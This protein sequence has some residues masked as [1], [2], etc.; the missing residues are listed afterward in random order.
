MKI[1]SR[2]SQRHKASVRIAFAGTLLCAS[3]T[4]SAK[5]EDEYQLKAA[6]LVNFLKFI[7]WP[8]SSG[9]YIIE[10]AGKN[11]FGS[12]LE[13]LANN[14]N[15]NGRKV[16]FRSE[17]H[18]G[19]GLPSIIFVPASELSRFADFLQYAKKPVVVIG[20]SSGF[21]RKFGAINFIHDHDRV[22][23]EINPKLAKASGV[24]VSSQLLQLARIVE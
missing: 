1:L 15:I 4:G 8:D 24:K 16:I 17:K 2:N 18:S 5:Q 9:P 6:F 3:L 11:P 23:F 14:R 7:E 12:P 10:V 13:S 20:E 19:N 21:A 22:A